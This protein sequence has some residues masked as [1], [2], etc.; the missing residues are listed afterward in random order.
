MSD[1]RS[2]LAVSV[3]LAKRSLFPEPP[4]PR[5]AVRG[6]PWKSSEE[7]AVAPENLPNLA[8]SASDA[9]RSSLA[10]NWLLE[11]AVALLKL[12]M[13]GAVEVEEVDVA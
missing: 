13:L 8:R 7:M 11:M 9:P 12:A 6:L 2:D 4:P 5:G 1:R 10:K 3:T